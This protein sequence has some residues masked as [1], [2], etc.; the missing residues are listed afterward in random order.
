MGQ[1]I[2]TDYVVIGGGSAGMSA[3]EHLTSH[4]A[5]AILI[6]GG[7]TGTTCARVGCM[8]SKLLIAASE[9]AQRG[10]LEVVVEVS[11]LPQQ[12][13]HLHTPPPRG[14]NAHQT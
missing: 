4:G 9:A 8:P 11:R 3:F 2:S 1:T 6:N 5:D 13:P 7:Y 10:E 12:P 14:G